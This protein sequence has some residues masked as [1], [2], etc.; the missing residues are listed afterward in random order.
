MSSEV[1]GA[2]TGMHDAFLTENPSFTYFNNQIQLEKP[3][4]IQTYIVPFDTVDNKI[5]TI[6]YF[7]DYVTDVTLKMT[8][9]GLVTT[10]D[11]FWTFT[12]PPPGNMYVYSSTRSL[13]PILTVSP[14]NINVNQIKSFNTLVPTISLV[15]SGPDFSIIMNSSGI[16]TTFGNNSSG[17]SQSNVLTINSYTVKKIAC[18]YAHTALLDTTG[19]VYTFGDNSKGQLGNGGILSNIYQPVASGA[20]DIEC[21]NYSTI[22]R[23]V[24]GNVFATGTNSNYGELGNTANFG[25][26]T[27]VLNFIQL[28]ELSTAGAVI[29]SF[30]AGP[31]FTMMIDNKNKNVYAAGNNNVGQLGRNTATSFL[32]NYGTC[33]FTSSGPTFNYPIT[34]VQTGTNFACFLTPTSNAATSLNNSLSAPSGITLDTTNNYLYTINSNNIYRFNLNINSLIL[35]VSGFS[36]PTSL[37]FDSTRNYLYVSD[38]QSIKLIKVSISNVPTAV[39]SS[40]YNTIAVDPVNNILYATNVSAGTVSTIN[41]S[42]GS[43]SVIVSN[44]VNP[45][46][47]VFDQTH[48]YLYIGSSNLITQVNL[49]TGVG[50]QIST[51]LSSPYSLT[52]SSKNMLYAASSNSISRIDLNDLNYR[53]NKLITVNALRSIVSSNTTTIYSTYGSNI[54]SYTSDNSLWIS[55]NKNIVFLQNTSRDTNIDLV[56]SNTVDSMYTNKYSNTF[57]YVSR[58]INSNGLNVS[59]N[60][61]SDVGVTITNRVALGNIQSN[62]LVNNT[63]FPQPNE[64]P[65]ISIGNF[66]LCGSLFF[67]NSTNGIIGTIGYNTQTLMALPSFVNDS[68]NFSFPF[69]TTQESSST[70]YISIV[71]DS[72]SVAN[73]FGYDYK[74]LTSIST[75]SYILSVLSP[76]YS[77]TQLLSPQNLRES[78]FIQGL[79]YIISGSSNTYASYESIIN[80]VSLYIGKQ[81]VQIIPSEFLEFKKEISTSYKNRPILKLLEGDGTNIVPSTRNYYIQ[82][83]ILK[84]IPIGALYNQDVQVVLDYNYISGMQM[85]LIVTYVKFSNIVTNTDYTIVVPTVSTTTPK[86]PCTKIFSSNTFTSLYL[87]GERMFDTN[88]SN[89]MPFENYVNIPITGKSVLFNSPINMS[90]IRDINITAPN[91]NVYYETLNIL[92]ISNGLGGLLFS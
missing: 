59:L 76:L 51:A 55:G 19:N 80:S 54:A 22:Y 4:V 30:K 8:L 20:L 46:G 58:F 67:G 27:K 68:F 29:D 74:D 18:G 13:D 37:A 91:S 25:V 7:G 21:C 83:N 56:L 15:G 16:F 32:S 90:R 2:V 23:D 52:L 24:N 1:Y 45:Y 66:F 61:L 49:N 88:S 72:I 82:T 92:N 87:N 36:T 71:F 48:N 14:V 79:N 38:S 10:N 31:D 62:I 12:N 64:M 78:G 43:S 70:T 26:S 42:G 3:N 28:T 35:Y 85:S 69:E 53:T 6:P 34:D 33:S 44:L 5:A 39:T 11:N 40:P 63:I 60:F 47:L 57:C 73:F 89:V 84:N 9:P 81:L 17:Q 65:I 50:T 86:G 75:N 77:P 41:T